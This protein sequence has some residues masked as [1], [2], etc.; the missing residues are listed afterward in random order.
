M[1]PIFFLPALIICCTW[2][3]L[4]S[5][6][7]DKNTVEVSAFYP[8][9]L[10]DNFVNNNFRDIVGLKISGQRTLSKHFSIGAFYSGA[11]HNEEIA[12]TDASGNVTSNDLVTLF[13][14]DFNAEGS[15]ILF[16]SSKNNLCFSLSAGY[17]LLNYRLEVPEPSEGN[18]NYSGYNITPGVELRRQIS[19][20]FKLSLACCYAYQHLFPTK[21][22][23]TISY[24]Q[25]IPTLEA[26][27]GV[28]FSF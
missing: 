18:K 9:S 7:Q 23:L 12:F 15:Y 26:G 22:F 21:D 27:I 14:H 20:H 2:C 24:N 5:S 6:A 11:L 17:T 4:S 10:G 19:N 13:I 8:L 3:S 25:N 1:K 28:S 16:P